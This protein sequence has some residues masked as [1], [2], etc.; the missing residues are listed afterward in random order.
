[1]CQQLFSTAFLI[2]SNLK[3]VTKQNTLPC[4][5]FEC[6]FVMYSSSSNSSQSANSCPKRRYSSLQTSSDYEHMKFRRNGGS[7]SSTKSNVSSL[8]SCSLRRSLLIDRY[9]SPSSER[10]TVSS[11][12]SLL[13]SYSLSL[14]I[15]LT[16]LP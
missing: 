9:C 16:F 7:S 15:W 3:I 4:I 13:S 10:S 8:S 6:H 5:A 14:C 12:V 11:N 1:M 2:F